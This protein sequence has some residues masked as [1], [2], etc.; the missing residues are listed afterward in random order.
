MCRWKKV[1]KPSPAFTRVHTRRTQR[2]PTALNESLNYHYMNLQHFVCRIQCL[3]SLLVCWSNSPNTALWVT[4]AVV[5]L[6]SDQL[7]TSEQGAVSI[8]AG[9]IIKLAVMYF[10]GSGYWAPT[11]EQRG[12]GRLLLSDRKFVHGASPVGWV[13]L[14]CKWSFWLR[15]WQEEAGVVALRMTSNIKSDKTNLINW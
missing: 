15:L 4:S 11:A 12:C 5:Q 3:F 8:V 14:R 1:N 6:K 10:Q 13:N 2:E 9:L 7:I